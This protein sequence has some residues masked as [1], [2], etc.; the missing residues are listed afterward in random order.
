MCL[1]GASGLAP[2]RFSRSLIRRS[3]G[4]R[5]QTHEGIL[6]GSCWLRQSTPW[7]VFLAARS[8]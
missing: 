6:L 7:A 1:H 8:S 4:G 5:D 3:L 2:R